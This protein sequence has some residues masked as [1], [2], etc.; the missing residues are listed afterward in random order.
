MKILIN[1]SKKLL[2]KSNNILAYFLFFISILFLI[3]S[4]FT[5]RRILLIQGEIFRKRSILSNRYLYFQFNNF[6]DIA[7]FPFEFRMAN[8]IYKTIFKIS[9]LFNLKNLIFS[10]S[11]KPA[12]DRIYSL[13]WNT[14]FE[15]NGNI[16]RALLAID[17]IFQLN[18]VKV[19]RIILPSIKPSS[20]VSKNKKKYTLSF[21]GHGDKGYENDLLNN[22]EDNS[23]QT[24]FES[25]DSFLKSREC[26][27]LSYI[28]ELSTNFENDFSLFG[29][30]WESYGLSYRPVLYKPNLR[31]YI[32][33]NSIACIDFLS[34]SGNSCLYHR[35]IEIL[36][37]G[38]ILIQ[39]RSYDSDFFFGENFANHLTFTSLS[40]LEIL[41]KKLNDKEFL[42]HATMIMNEARY[43]A[44]LRQSEQNQ[45]LHSFLK[46]NTPKITK[47]QTK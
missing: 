6:F 18:N 30:G 1:L 22:I 17:D 11:D 29:S 31:L 3:L 8:K 45:D 5:S 13:W 21:I 46:Q 34:K 12:T 37:S 40:S 15:I 28:K 26:A 23:M 42:N 43:L 36:N 47:P 33:R 10:I 9:H 44:K 16:N 35:T 39:K 2:K 32:Y 20:P 19:K 41:V 24:K 25:Y 4:A 14:S 38:S 27:R 7:F